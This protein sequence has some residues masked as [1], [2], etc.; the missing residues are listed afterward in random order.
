MRPPCEFASFDLVDDTATGGTSTF[1]TKYL[2][3]H[4]ERN[5]NFVTNVVETYDSVAQT[6]TKRIEW[7]R[8][9]FFTIRKDK[10]TCIVNLCRSIWVTFHPESIGKGELLDVEFVGD[11]DIVIPAA[12]DIFPDGT[13]NHVEMATVC[14]EI[15][16]R[17]NMT[18]EGW[19]RTIPFISPYKK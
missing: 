15:L 12:D 6:I 13:L 17:Y 18:K 7:Y 9:V 5:E 16:I 11:P 3:C 1:T 8:P 14:R 4:E 19:L 10:N 2:S